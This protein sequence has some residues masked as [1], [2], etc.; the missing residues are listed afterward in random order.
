MNRRIKQLFLGLL[1]FFPLLL[2]GCS[3]EFVT[4]PYRVDLNYTEC[5]I[6]VNEGMQLSLSVVGRSGTLKSSEYSY[7]WSSSDTDVAKVSAAGYVTAVDAGKAFVFANVHILNSNKILVEKCS[8]TVIDSEPVSVSLNKETVDIQQGKYTQ[9][10]AVVE[11]TSNKKVL[12]K[13]DNSLISVDQYGD[14][15]VNSS[16]PIGTTAVITATSVFNPAM[17]ASCTVTVIEPEEVQLDYTIMY[18]MSGSTLEYDDSKSGSECNIGL[19]SEDIKEILSVELPENVR[20]IIETGGTKKW[21]LSSD[22]IV[23]ADSIS[24]QKLQRWEVCGG[25]IQLIDSLGTNKMSTK[26]S[27][28][29][30]LKWGLSEYEANQMGVVVS[31]HGSGIGGCAPDDNNNSDYLTIKEMVDA[32]TGA[33]NMSEREK[34]TWL[35]FDCCMMQSADLASVI[36]DNFDYMV[37]S[38]ESEFGEGWDHDIYLKELAKDTKIEPQKL[39]SSVASSFVDSYDKTSCLLTEPC[40][41]TMS[42]LDLSK[43]DN[44]VRHFNNFTEQVGTS[45]SSKVDY[46]VYSSAFRNSLNRFGSKKYG[47]VDVKD[48]ISHIGTLKADVSI[49]EL[50]NAL[51]DL[52]IVNN[53]CSKYAVKPC[54]LNA[55]FPESADSKSKLQILKSDYQDGVT[56]FVD[57]QK[58]CLAYGSFYF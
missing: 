15:I 17:S 41:Q 33:I 34:F 30:F 14:V 54:G 24:N 49:D 37:A 16:V 7:T 57:Y 18:Y 9:L 51:S 1:G 55:F 53:F 10:F 39:L 38:Q 5:S 29:S 31:G 23:G 44:F 4:R 8:I 48:F 47:L 21:N 50:L 26:D 40:Y 25:K 36:S 11:H 6:S 32:T 12:W 2:S 20:L 43:M 45:R 22:Y 42:V 3:F 56:K 27:F 28:E 58:M 19:F 35:G 46:A 13:S 52:V